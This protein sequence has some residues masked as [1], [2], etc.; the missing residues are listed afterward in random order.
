L[1]ERR[2]RMSSLPRMLFVCIENACRSQMAEAFAGKLGAGRIEACSAG[3]RPAGGVNPRAIAFMAERGIDISGR[4]PK[5]LS[6]FAD[7]AFDV[8]VTM[9][10]GDACP[11]LPAKRRVDWALPDPKAL[12]GDGFRAVRDE[13]ESRV[14]QLLSELDASALK[15]LP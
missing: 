12:P 5:P 4:V 15:A 14:Q 9:G 11:W 2:L 6:A 10:C 13:I 7:Q 3:S 1:R 8:V